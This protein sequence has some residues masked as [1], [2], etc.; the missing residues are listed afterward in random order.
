MAVDGVVKGN[1]R[2]VNF[3]G[4]SVVLPTA[5]RLKATGYVADPLNLQ[6]MKADADLKIMLAHAAEAP[7]EEVEN[8]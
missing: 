6:R 7:P 8:D 4:L 1:L 5:F 2:R 3:T